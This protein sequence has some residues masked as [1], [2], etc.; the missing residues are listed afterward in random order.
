M[1]MLAKEFLL[2]GKRDLGQAFE[3][4]PYQLFDL[5]QFAE[6]RLKELQYTYSDY[7]QPHSLTRIAEHFQLGISYYKL[8]RCVG[9]TQGTERFL[10]RIVLPML[11]K[12]YSVYEKWVWL[13]R[14]QL[15]K[16]LQMDRRVRDIPG[17]DDGVSENLHKI[18]HEFLERRMDDDEYEEVRHTHELFRVADLMLYA[19]VKMAQLN[20]K[21]KGEDGLRAAC[22]AIENLFR[23]NQVCIEKDTIIV[24]ALSAMCCMTEFDFIYHTSVSPIEA[25]PCIRNN[26]AVCFKPLPVTDDDAMILGKKFNIWSITQLYTAFLQMDALEQENFLSQVNDSLHGTIQIEQVDKAFKIWKEDNYA[27]LKTFKQKKS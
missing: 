27:R 8:L 18:I 17:L 4:F 2:E 5:T 20:I 26:N 22:K 11:Q 15:E 16:W 7:F 10:S 6:D 3:L 9:A 13:L 12:D 24:S 1:T 21:I 19:S 25:F 14:N 23:S